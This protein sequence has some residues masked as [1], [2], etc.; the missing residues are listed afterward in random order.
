[1]LFVPRG[2]ITASLATVTCAT[3]ANP[4]MS[5]QVKQVTL[6]P[7]SLCIRWAPVQA[8]RAH[9][10]WTQ[11]V[12]S[13]CM[14]ANARSAYLSVL[15]YSHREATS[16]ALRAMQPLRSS[17]SRGRPCSREAAPL[18]T[19]ANMLAKSTVCRSCAAHRA[20]LTLEAPVYA[21]TMPLTAALLKPADSDINMSFLCLLLCFA[22]IAV[23]L[24]SMLRVLSLRRWLRVH[25]G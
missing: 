20:R 19:A 15:K 9:P 23:Q 21:V 5:M 12:S 22:S 10:V 7:G 16:S 2:N 6:K 18:D 3:I 17:L 1:M 11:L 25:V 13:I 24:L 4:D 14:L 8:I